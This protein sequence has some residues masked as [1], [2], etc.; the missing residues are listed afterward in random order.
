MQGGGFRMMSTSPQADGETRPHKAPAPEA[1]IADA[2]RGDQRALEQLLECYRNYLRLLSR[3][4]LDNELGAKVGASDLVQETLIK[5]H[6]RFDQFRGRTEKE[7]V[8]WL[9]SILAR[10]LVDLVRRFELNAG[11]RL[12]RESDAGLKRLLRF[13]RRHRGALGDVRGAASNLPIDKAL[14]PG[15]V[16][17]NAHIDNVRLRPGVLPEDAY[18]RA[19]CE[20]VRNHLRG[21]LF[22]KRRHALVRHAVVAGE[23]EDRLVAQSRLHR[24]GG[25]AVASREI[26]EISETPLWFRQVVEV[27]T[28]LWL[29]RLVYRLD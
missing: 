23:G 8:G 17:V 1:L 28:Y 21:Y 13:V 14:G 4:S 10:H 7:L 12:A 25:E 18:G 11:R 24:P 26:L 22:G 15:E 2:Q 3:T 5:A 16:G 19:A 9:R 29:E 6:A 20:H 27:R